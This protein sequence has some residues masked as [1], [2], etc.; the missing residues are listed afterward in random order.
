FDFLEVGP[1]PV[2]LAMGR[3]FC[4]GNGN[5]WLES[6]RRGATES[7]QMLLSLS[8]L[9]VTGAKVDWEG[10]DKPY[11]PPRITQPTYPF[12]RELYWMDEDEEREDSSFLEA[13]GFHPLLGRRIRLAGSRELRFQSRISRGKPAYLDDHRLFDKPV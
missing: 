7:R 6:L 8:R 10:F 3:E 9:Y 2:L 12:Q 5:M 1:H 11:K 4:N 13:S